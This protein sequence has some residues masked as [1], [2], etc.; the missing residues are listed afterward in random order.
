MFTD[1]QNLGDLVENE[2]DEYED[3]EDMDEEEVYMIL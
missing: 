2:S 3:L 1:T